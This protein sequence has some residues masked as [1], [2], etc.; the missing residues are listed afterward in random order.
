M[1][2]TSKVLGALV[3]AAALTGSVAAASTQQAPHSHTADAPHADLPPSQEAQAAS[4]GPEVAPYPLYQTFALHSRASATRKIFLDFDGYTTSGTRWNSTY[5]AGAPIVSTPFNPDGAAGFSAAEQA[6]IQRAYLLL[7]EDFAPFNVDVT[8]Q[9]PGVEGL[10]KTS[11]D[12]VAYGT[13]VVISP[14]FFY[15]EPAGGVAYLDTFDGAVDLPAFV[16]SNYAKSS[17]AVGEVAAHELGHSLGLRH[18]GTIPSATPA[19]ADPEYY[20][21]QGSWGPILGTASSR[22][23]TQWSRG[24]YYGANNTE[25]DLAV[26]TSNGLSFVP[27][28]VV[29]TAATTATLPAG[30]RRYGVIS[31]PGEVDAYKFTLNASERVRIHGWNNVGGVDP[32]LNLRGQLRTSAGTLVVTASPTSS[33]G[34]DFT[35]TLPAGSYV[36]HLTGVGEGSSLSTGYSNYGSLGFYGT[37]LTWA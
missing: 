13:R 6:V 28:D 26:I 24:Q 31:A 30:T 20:W 2:A 10:R 37:Q 11:V 19:G 1:I 29:G 7:R 9:D 22:S 5:T 27:D 21:G 32:N 23:I 25:D 8:T 14:T 3:L 18:D 34:F 36:L 15:P 33:T 35:T 12:D 17:K 16:F 4:S